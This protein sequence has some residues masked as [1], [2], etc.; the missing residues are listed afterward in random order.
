MAPLRYKYRKIISANIG[1]HII[2]ALWTA[3]VL[4]CETIFSED[5]RNCSLKILSIIS[6]N[7]WLVVSNLELFQY[8]FKVLVIISPAISPCSNFVTP[9]GRVLIYKIF[10]TQCFL[11]VNLM[12]MS[13]STYADHKF[14]R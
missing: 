11:T 7:N 5:K 6:S 4:T 3:E 13:H 2:K 8:T 1:L 14:A 12:F 9:K 10:I